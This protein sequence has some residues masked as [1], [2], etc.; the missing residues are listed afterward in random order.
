MVKTL[1][2]EAL[3]AFC[4]AAE[5]GTLSRAA[6]SLEVAQSMLSRRIATLERR[7]GVMLFHRTGRGV[8]P[9]DVGQR[10]LP[11]ARAI[12][13]EAAGLV[14]EARGERDSPAGV[15]ELGVVPVVARPLVGA[16]VRKLRNEYPRIRLRVN[17]G[18]S[19]QI[20]AWLAAGRVDLGLFN[21]YGRG[22]VR[23]AEPFLESDIVLVRRRM[24]API[25]GDA[26]PFRA[27]DGLPL[28]LPTRPNPLFALAVDLAARQK[29]TL[30]IALEAG[31]GAL[32]RDAVID[33]GLSTLVP[34]HLALRDYAGNRFLRA[35][36]VAPV[37]HQKT[38]L[39]FTSQ[40]PLGLAART[41]GRI[42]RDMAGN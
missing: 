20:E 30:D 27:L 14:E 17:E 28:V 39:A 5:H 29:I 11:R 40:H 4:A 18:Y 9:T 34:E 32:V 33:A 23:G 22:W 25:H 8:L 41:V 1:D 35:R 37:L 21:R 12:L 36:I 15:V 38:W 16:L 2:H 6:A 19:G 42:V 13:A 26:I 24:G 10:L 3:Q 31:S 7:L